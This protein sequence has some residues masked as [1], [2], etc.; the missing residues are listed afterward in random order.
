MRPSTKAKRAKRR[1][2]DSPSKSGLPQDSG[3]LIE[4]DVG[5]FGVPI[6]S[7]TRA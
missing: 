1:I 3:A 5:S 4:V 6:K 7:M 2:D